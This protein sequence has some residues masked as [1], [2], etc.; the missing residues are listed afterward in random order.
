M[1]G[2]LG[3]LSCQRENFTN[4]GPNVVV[5]WL[6]TLALSSG[7]PRLKSQTGDRLLTEM[8][9]VFLISSR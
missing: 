3:F 2:L 8:F 7:S 6:N 4:E 9:V 5:D 1:C